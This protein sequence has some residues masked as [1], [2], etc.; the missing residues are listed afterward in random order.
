[1]KSQYKK[2]VVLFFCCIFSVFFLSLHAQNIR[3]KGEIRDSA[4]VGIANA[5]V[6]LTAVKDS[7]LAGFGVSN[8][9]GFFQIDIDSKGKYILQMS[10]MGFEENTQIVDIQE[11]ISENIILKNQ[12][13]NLKEF[14]VTTEKTP[15]QIKKDTVEYNAQY[16]K[17]QPGSVIED[18]LKKLPGVEVDASGQIKANGE[19]IKTVLVDG[20]EF[21][22]NDPTMATKNLPAD[23][24]DKI[25]M[26]DK[27]SEEAEFAGIRDGNEEKTINIKLKNG[28]KQGTFG[29]MEGGYGTSNRYQ[30]KGNV[31]NFARNRQLSLIGIANN[32]NTEGFSIREYLQFMGGMSNMGGGRGGRTMIR[33]GGGDM[34]IGGAGNNISGILQTLGTGLNWN[35]QFGKKTKTH[36]SYFVNHLENDV[37]TNTNRVGLLQKNKYTTLSDA[38]DTSRSLNHK[39]NSYLKHDFDSTQN[40]KVKLDV[41]WKDAEQQSL[42]N[43]S[44][45]DVVLKSQSV[46]NNRSLGE[47]FDYTT[48]LMYRKRLGKIGRTTSLSGTYGNSSDVRNADLLS[49][50]SFPQQGLS[51]KSFQ[52]QDYEDRQNNYSVR[53]NYTEP[54][55]KN[56]SLSLILSR[57]NFANRTSK[58]FYTTNPWTQNKEIDSLNSNRFDRAYIY[59]RVATN[60]QKTSKK[61]DFFARLAFQNSMLKN[62]L[63]NENKPFNANFNNILPSLRYEYRFANSHHLNLDYSTNVQEPSLQDLQPIVDNSNPLSVFVGNPSL[64]PAYE[65]DFN[66][67][68]LNYD[69]FNFRSFF[70][71]VNTAYTTN[72]INYSR[73][74]NSDLGEIIKPVNVDYDFS[75]NASADFS[76]PIRPIKCIFKSGV[77]FTYNRALQF[78]NQQLTPADYYNT[79]FNLTL[80]NR[81][82]EK[83]DWLIGMKKSVNQ[84][85]FTQGENRVHQ[86]FITDNYFAEITWNVTKKFSIQSKCDYRIFKGSF[87]TQYFPL[88]QASA[89]H[90]FL[91]SKKLRLKLTCFDILNTNN[92]LQRNAQFN[93]YQEVRTNVLQRYFLLTL[94]YSLQGF[95]ERGDGFQMKRR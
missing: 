25:Q 13:T 95:K 5:S 65:H 37:A 53:L 73:E 62:R 67:S 6:M 74:I 29:N 23:I 70:A 44:N 2:T 72:K 38:Q 35:Q 66:I 43:Q 18:L 51:I 64:R 59:Q 81:K 50:N 61:W 33:V 21:F 89:V 15:M 16:F 24:V 26:F 83:I 7:S 88:W 71:N 79:G 36:L 28:K 55:G 41:S 77:N 12:A 48:S 85:N 75:T 34:P 80:E 39:I 93:F 17:T 54:L 90:Y 68:Y 87:E 63:L 14:V 84:N 30:F 20:K 92:G 91:P 42:L 52:Q 8:D 31:N 82:K 58:L 19:R 1:M 45:S 32:T 3:F 57:Q 47:T 56:R 27:R 10:A 11:D 94:G 40:I 69:Q 49:E 22:G 78:V 9:K 60:F 86:S 76:T 46:Q 4:G